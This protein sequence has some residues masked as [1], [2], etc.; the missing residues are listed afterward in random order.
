MFYISNYPLEN[1][2]S[3][4]LLFGGAI[5]WTQIE[6]FFYLTCTN[7]LC[8]KAIGI[9]E[10]TKKAFKSKRLEMLRKQLIQVLAESY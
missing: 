10:D 2:K 9:P 5:K 4:F 8:I 7:L 6:R 1:S 3:S